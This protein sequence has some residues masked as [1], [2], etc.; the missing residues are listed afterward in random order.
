VDLSFLPSVNAALNATA[1]VLLV[2][3]RRLARNDRFE[4]HRR[5]MTAA[6]AVSSLFLVLYVTHKASRGFVNTELH[7]EGIAHVAYLV[8]LSTHVTLAMTV[9]GFAI[10]LVVLAVRGRR[11]RHRRLARVAWPIWMYVSVTGVLI[12]VLLYHLNP[13]PI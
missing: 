8:M 11:D 12:Y 3:G 10:A 6:F 4:A 5:V 7:V 13:A 1:A 9:P 2:V